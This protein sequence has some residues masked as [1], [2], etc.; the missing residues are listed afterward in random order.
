M[1][2]FFTMLGSAARAMDAQRF[3]LDVTGQNIANVNTPGYTRRRA[4][5][6]EVPARTPLSAGGGVEVDGVVA[7]RDRFVERRLL[8]ELPEE[9]RHAALAASLTGAELA[10]GEAGASLDARLS[11]F[12]D[13]FARLSDVPTSSTARDEVVLQGQALAG[14]FNEMGQRLVKAE[15]DTD[16][17]IRTTVEDI[18]A[19]AARIAQLNG[20][21]S[22][23][24]ANSP[25][26]L[27][28]RDEV[29]QAVEQLSQLARAE[30]L[31]RPEGGYDVAIG[32]GRTLVVGP[33][34]YPLTVAPR[35]TT[36]YADV[37]AADG[38]V[39]TAEIS[40][41]RLA[42]MI[43]ARDTFMPAYSASLDELAYT[44]AGEV[45]TIHQAGY[46]G[47]G[48]AGQPFFT[49]L[50]TTSNAARLMAVN[51]ALLAPNGGTLVVASAD[52][53]AAGD[54]AAARALAA[55]RDS[56]VLTAGTA[57]FGDFWSGIVYRVGRDIRA[58]R[59]EQQTRS[60]L[61]RQLEVLRD[62]ASGV[63]LDEEAA[64][65]MRFQRAYEANARYF[66]AV[67][68]SLATLLG[69]VGA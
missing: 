65:L 20:T 60:E 6:S 29:R 45:N 23:A 36:G 55:L 12:F 18:N 68:Q 69:I 1:S 38:T 25:Q 17:M 30:A 34:A 21:L 66:Q 2:G 61:V 56:R 40:S 14:S 57:T 5:M 62:S 15:R 43:Q 26:A 8:A 24:P 37:L 67:D 7:E 54:N 42:G 16:A 63:S 48:A 22:S 59:D 46:D 31:E 64:N 9:Q 35:P 19:L 32:H 39:L 49:P 52:P 10:L 47:T 53:A 41:G 33:N 13:A 28:A 58:A 51:P 4:L 44:V 50:A 3:A 11:A 27:Q